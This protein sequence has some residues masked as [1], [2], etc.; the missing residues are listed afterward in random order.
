MEIVLKSPQVQMYIIS[1]CFEGPFICTAFI[2]S[3]VNILIGRSIKEIY[4]TCNYC[5][6]GCE[7]DRSSEFYISAQPGWDEKP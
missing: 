2:K 1:P 5:G 4:V 7:N 3:S 6:S